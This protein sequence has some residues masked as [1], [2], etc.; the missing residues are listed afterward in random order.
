[1]LTDPIFLGLDIGTSSCKALAIDARARLLGSALA[2]YPCQS[3][4]PGW[5]EQ[6]PADWRHG[7][8]TALRCLLKQLDASRLAGIGLSGQMH[9]MVALGA[10]NNVLRPAI[11]WNDQRT[12]RQCAEITALAGGA[13]G[14]LRLTNNPML[15]GFTGGKIMWF[16]QTEPLLFEQT[17]TFLNPKDY[18]RFCLTGQLATEVSDASGT[19]LFDVKHR[20]WSQELLALLELEASLFPPALESTQIAGHV[21]RAAAELTGLPAGL[22]VIAGGGDA[23]LSALGMGVSSQSQIAVTLGTSGVVARHCA[24][25]FENTGGKLQFSCACLPGQFHVMGVTLAAAGSYQWLERV[26]GDAS[27][28]ERRARYK[29]LDEEAFT[30]P[31]GAEGLLFLPYLSGERCPVNDPAARGVF[32]GL[33]AATARGGIARAV[34]EGVA[35]SLRQVYGLIAQAGGAAEQVVLAGGGAVSPLW[36]QIIADVFALPTVTLEAGEEGSGLGAAMLA[37]LGLR[38]W[39]DPQSAAVCLREKTKALP[40]PANAAV[41]EQGYQQYL[42]L[43]P[44][45]RNLR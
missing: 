6:N 14:L 26:L 41:Y 15:T 12:P 34:L 19:G 27:L 9:G 5:S 30:A 40:N 7:A 2:E 10:K 44:A 37:G 36:R 3:P 22:P 17:K 42:R 32:F 21:T 11:L 13:E 18:I 20:R 35:Y 23:V 39:S 25:W 28:P 43:Y 4:Q 8:Q 24:D 33:T 29:A 16:R 1:M 45:I 31:P 38:Y